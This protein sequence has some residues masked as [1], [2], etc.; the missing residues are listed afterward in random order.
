M[1]LSDRKCF[2]TRYIKNWKWIGN[3]QN[4]FGLKVNYTWSGPKYTILLDWMCRK[5]TNEILEIF[6]ISKMQANSFNFSKVQSFLN[7]KLGTNSRA[8][9]LLYYQD[10]ET[11]TSHM[12]TQ[13]KILRK[14]ERINTY[15]IVHL[16]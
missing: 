3:F 5:K 4:T 6:R 14:K 1:R 9:Y 8:T 13:K 15:Q 12:H 11:S 16:F 7:Q 2:G 10:F